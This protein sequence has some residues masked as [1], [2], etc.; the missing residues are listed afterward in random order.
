VLDRAG[1]LHLLVRSDLKSVNVDEKSLMPDD[2]SRRLSKSEID[3]LI[4]FL[5]R[6]SVR[7]FEGESQ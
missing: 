4:A 5:S 7:P 1:R 3:D 2:L 6:Q